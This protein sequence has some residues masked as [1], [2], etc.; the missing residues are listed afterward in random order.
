M[1]DL[2]KLLATHINNIREDLNSI[3]DC[4][5]GHKMKMGG[6]DGNKQ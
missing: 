4:R 5:I 6:D 2:D 3:Y 1:K